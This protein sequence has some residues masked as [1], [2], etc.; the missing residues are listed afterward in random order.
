MCMNKPIVFFLLLVFNLN[1]AMDRSKDLFSQQPNFV[2]RLIIQ[3]LL[4]SSESIHDDRKLLCSLALINKQSRDQV[5]CPFFMRSII[6]FLGKKYQDADKII[7]YQLRLPGAIQYDNMCDELYKLTTKRTCDNVEPAIRDLIHKGA[8]L[9]A[10]YGVYGVSILM[11]AGLHVQPEF[12]DFLLKQGA[13]VGARDFLG[14]S[15]LSHV[16]SPV[17]R[18]CVQVLLQHGADVNEFDRSGKTFLMKFVHQADIDYVRLF[19]YYRADVNARSSRDD[20]VRDHNVI[21]CAK[22]IRKIIKSLVDEM[23]AMEQN[24]RQFQAKRVDISSYL[25]QMP[26]AKKLKN[27]LAIDAL[28]EECGAQTR[29]SD[30]NHPLLILIENNGNILNRLFQYIYQDDEG[31]EQGDDLIVPKNVDKCLSSI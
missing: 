20:Y 16:V 2:K 4:Q 30:K 31:W 26:E 29:V 21:Y 13:D 11:N 23:W 10:R 5:N 6:N 15:V 8:W 22:N 19:V 14:T 3:P 27:A 12:I 9:N 1:Y 25:R 28:L 17:R 24:N 7:A 18:D